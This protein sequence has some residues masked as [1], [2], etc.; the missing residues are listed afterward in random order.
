MRRRSFWFITLALICQLLLGSH[1]VTNGLLSAQESSASPP[2]AAVNIATIRARTQEKA[3]DVYNL[4]GDAEVDYKGFV[5]RADEAS[6]NEATG[7]LTARG[8]VSLDGGPYDEHLAASHGSYNLQTDTGKFYEAWGT[9]GYRFKGKGVTLTT[10]APLAFTG[11]EVEKVG[12]ERYVI[13]HGTLTSCELPKPKWKYS[14]ARIVLEVGGN[15]HIYNSIFDVKKVP[16][17]YLPYAQHPA[18]KLPRESGFLLPTYGTSSLKG[19]IIGDAYYWVINRSMDATIGAQYW[20]S[21]GWAQEGEFRFRPSADSYVQANYFGVVD[22]RTHP[23]NVDESGQDIRLN[24]VGMFPHDIRGVASLEY[25]SSYI[26]RQSF[27]ETFSQ[28]INSEVIS[29]AFLSKNQDGFSF[30]LQGSRY[31]NF[32]STQPDD[33]IT[34]VHAP[35]LESA[36]SDRSFGDSRLFWSYE[37]EAA[38]LSRSEPGFQTSALV[39][40]FDL[41]PQLSL[42]LVE[43]GW[44]FRP[45]LSFRETAYT[46]TLLPGPGIGRAVTDPV[47]RATVEAGFELRPPSL[48]RVFKKPV[49]HHRLKHT[50]EPRVVY[51]YVH[52]IDNFAQIIRF[53]GRDILSNTNEF[54]FGLVN[55][56]YAKHLS[57]SCEG[58]AE[59]HSAEK[60]AAS[61]VAEMPREIVTWEVG[62]K[63]F[64]DRDF[65]GAL[66]NGQRNVFTTTDAFSGIAFLT[67]PRRASPVISRLRIQPNLRSSVQWNL[68][69]DAKKGRINSSTLFADY[70][71]HDFLLGAG[72]TYLVTAGEAVTSGLTT[73]P[74]PAKFDQFRISAGYG[75]LNKR[76][77]TLVNTFGYDMRSGFLQYAAVQ[78]SYN[79]DCCG[80][81]MEYR[82]F[83]LGSLRNENEYRFSFSL[84]NIGTFGNLKRTERLY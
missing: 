23:A 64:L 57:E 84:A 47:N 65:G 63:I 8:H 54:G 3:G 22:R 80:I 56:L 52:G 6:Y 72:H 79:W 1:L 48:T 10:S 36:S 38:G 62:E 4:H 68:D 76:G 60:D 21:V 12:P 67:D 27:A 51:D 50:I 46:Q 14:A 33:V 41:Q 31:Q 74:I 55:R 39:G 73:V 58:A 20:S 82:R 13:H 81:T 18:E 32:Q 24:A 11:K 66:V 15:A 19:F 25:L 75:N 30:N 44:S 78:S 16:V 43:G 35:S 42:S 37:T 26:F 5:F 59:Q 28:A 2:S 77:F 83:A 9:T 70:R 34:I 40:R 29:T 49:L 17:V 45:E 7:D 69:Y 61:C 71:F 53:D